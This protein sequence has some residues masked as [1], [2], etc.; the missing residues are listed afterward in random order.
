MRAISLGNVDEGIIFTGTWTCTYG[1]TTQS[2]NWSLEADEFEV[3]ASD[4]LAGSECTVAE[5]ATE[6]APNTKD[7]S[8]KWMPAAFEGNNATI[9]ANSTAHVDVVNSVERKLG[10]LE[11]TKKL[12]GETAGFTGSDSESFKVSY[13][14][15]NPLD[16]KAMSISDSVLLAAG[17]VKTVG[18]V[19]FGWDCEFSETAPSA[20]LLKDAS[21]VWGAPVIDRAKVSMGAETNGSTVTVTNTIGR[22]YGALEI[23]KRI[24]GVHAEVA[25]EGIAFTGTWTCI[26]DGATSRGEWSMEA[27][28]SKT[29]AADLLVGSD[30]TVAENTIEQKPNTNDRSYVWLPAAFEGNNATI[31]ANKT[32]HVGVVNSIERKLG[33]L[34]VAKTLSGETTGFTGGEKEGFEVTYTCVNPLDIEPKSVKASSVSGSV[35]LAADGTKTVGSVPFG[36]DCEFNETAPGADLLED[37][38]FVW[39]TPVIDRAE[40]SMG[41]DTNGS[42]VIVTNPIERNLGA[43][44]VDKSVRA[45]DYLGGGKWKITYDITVKNPLDSQSIYTLNDKLN[46]GEGMVVDSARYQELGGEWTAWEQTDREAVL[47]TDRK[48]ERSQGEQ[49]A[50]HA[51]QVEVTA[52]VPAEIIGSDAA[53]CDVENESAGG[54]FL[55]T[56]T[57]TAGEHSA[58]D[59]ACATPMPTALSYSMEKASDPASGKTVSPGDAINY[60]VMVKNTGEFIYSGAVVTDEMSGWQ[61][62]ATLNEGSLSVSGGEVATEGSKLVWTVGDLAVGESKTLTYA[63]TVNAEAWDQVLVNV[64]SGNGDVPPSTTTHP[65]PE[66]HKLPEPPVVEPPVVEKPTPELPGKETEVPLPPAVVE[67]PV[68]EDPVAE[69][70]APELPGKETQLPTTPKH[71]EVAPKLQGK[72]TQVSAPEQKAPLAATGASEAALWVVGSAALI[73]L[74]GAGLVVVSRRRKGSES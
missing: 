59:T 20:N 69:E 25:D 70:P 15:V 26:Y 5:N 37:A 47:A 41:E 8:Y 71:E 39:G 27:G 56:V 44:D 19:P 45:T 61:Q 10:S 30:C 48:I 31:T 62:A 35:L 46:F 1:E 55:N 73:M 33:T 63:V 53:T 57:V 3:V 23:S 13:T 16:E 11:I 64:A 2:G 72:E 38:S 34:N 36:W 68:D 50:Q 52:S 12:S 60:T 4:L 43:V 40:V 17:G 32:A 49:V 18:S 22:G 14:C 29:V 7:A 74:L 9:D 66:Y 65:T 42:T 28:E 24:V 21:F 6:Q 58:S 51:Y 54:G 67:P